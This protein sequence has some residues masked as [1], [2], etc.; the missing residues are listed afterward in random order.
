MSADTARDTGIPY[1]RVGGIPKAAK[2][3]HFEVGQYTILDSSG[4]QGSRR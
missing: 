3:S 2:Y 1:H 4:E